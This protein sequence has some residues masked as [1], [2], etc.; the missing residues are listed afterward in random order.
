MKI[1]VVAG[2][3]VAAVSANAQVNLTG[4]GSFALGGIFS[5]LGVSPTYTPGS[6]VSSIVLNNSGGGFGSLNQWWFS[7]VDTTANL[8]TISYSITLNGVN[9][10]TTVAGLVTAQSYDPVSG[11]IGPQYYLIGGPSGFVDALPGWNGAT[12]TLTVTDDLTAFGTPTAFFKGNFTFFNVVPEPTGVAALSIG[13]LGLLI[14][15][16]KSK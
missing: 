3:A 6:S 8:T 13:A 15:R 2:V 10:N 9:A 7:A 1:L 12:H 4:A 11:Q 14:R 5:G 16:R